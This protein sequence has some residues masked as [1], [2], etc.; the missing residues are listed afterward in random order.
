MI[1]TRSLVDKV[2]EHILTEI[3]NGEIQY[4]ENINIKQIAEELSISTMP[5]REALKRLEFEHIVSI[6]PRSSCSLLK[7]S[8]KMIREVYRLREVIELYAATEGEGSKDPARLKQLD[9]IV[10]EMRK[11]DKE[12]VSVTAR[13]KRA[14]SLDRDFHSVLCGLADSEFMSAIHR[15]LSLHVNMTLIHEKTYHKLEANWAE[16]HAVIVRALEKNPS[17]V[18]D[19]LRKHFEDVLRFF[20]EDEGDSAPVPGGRASKGVR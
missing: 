11:L 5:V 7:P 3:I 9:A 2:Y 14:I 1:D 15:Q 12:K 13:E 17:R 8:R 19:V 16:S 10:E 4:G 20:P 6:K 18:P